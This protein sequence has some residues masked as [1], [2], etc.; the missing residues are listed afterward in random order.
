MTHK[1]YKPHV[2]GPENNITT[3]DITIDRVLMLNGGAR[4]YLPVHR[5]VPGIELQVAR[6]EIEVTP[7]YSLVAAGGGALVGVAALVRK[8]G[9]SEVSGDVL[10]ARSAWRLRNVVDHLSSLQLSVTGEAGD[11]SILLEEL[12]QPADISDTLAGKEPNLPRGILALCLASS[13]SFTCQAPTAIS[14]HMNDDKLG[15]RLL[16]ATRLL[17]V[18]SDRWDQRPSPRYTV[19]PVGEVQHYI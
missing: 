14:V 18:D 1:L 4:A 3:P 7:A 13:A 17:S 5:L 15:R 9:D 16:H 6:G 12:L 8:A 10:I 2:V 19:G 11:A